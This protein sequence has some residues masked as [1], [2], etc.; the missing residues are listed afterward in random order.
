MEPFYQLGRYRLTEKIAAGGMG[1]IYRATYMGENGFLKTVAIKRLLPEWSSNKEFIAMLID[2]AKAQAQ[3]AHPNIVQ[4]IELGRDGN[5][6]FISMEYVDGINLGQLSNKILR[7]NEKIPLKF[8]IYIISQILNALNF[9]H[10]LCGPDGSP[11]N[12]VHRDISPP[13]VLCSWNGEV[14]VADFGIAKGMHRT[15]KTCSSQLKGK[16]SYMSPE[17]ARGENIDRQSDI[18]ATGIIFYELITGARLFEAPSDLEVIELVKKGQIPHSLLNGVEPNLKKIILRA[19]SLKKEKR[20]RSAKDF[21]SQLNEYAVKNNQLTSVFE[22]G[23]Y[24]CRLFP[25]KERIILRDLK[26]N[27][28]DRRKTKPLSSSSSLLAKK[29][30]Y[31]FLLRC[32]ILFVLLLCI[33]IPGT[34][35]KGKIIHSHTPSASLENLSNLEVN[36]AADQKPQDEEV[37]PAYISIQAV[38]WGFVSI[39]GLF[40]KKETPIQNA[41]IAP[42]NYILKVFHEPTNQ[43]LQKKISLKSESKIMC[44]ARFGENPSIFCK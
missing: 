12:I 2:E 27:Y 19:L 40:S 42:G 38:P 21:L 41:R 29:R 35:L 6:Y 18:Y 33:F 7:S 39:P 14:K 8:I 20:Y 34:T 5:D 4:V 1:E 37:K 22:F 36:K 24:L 10:N 11:L 15:Y 17:Q 26:N 16:Y 30:R 43:S 3:L 32:H 31:A 28:Q 25:Q 44:I 13:N 9:A 23:Q